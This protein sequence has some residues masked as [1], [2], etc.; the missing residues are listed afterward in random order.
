M[1]NFLKLA[2]VGAVE[3]VGSLWDLSREQESGKDE[4]G[5]GQAQCVSPT[6][7]AWKSKKCQ[8]FSA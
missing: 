7:G 6:R 5:R 2:C 4:Q 8:F 3:E 1:L